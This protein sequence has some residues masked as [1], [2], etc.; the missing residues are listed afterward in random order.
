[1]P[2]GGGGG[3][4]E[5]G[6]WLGGKQ[7]KGGA[8]TDAGHPNDNGINFK[9]NP[10]GRLLAREHLAP[11]TEHEHYTCILYSHTLCIIISF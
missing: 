1:M 8:A 3:G 10:E 11:N 4:G 9:L 2:A 5:R 6:V 7:S